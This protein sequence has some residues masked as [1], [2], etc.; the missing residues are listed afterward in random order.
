MTPVTNMTSP[1]TP[2]TLST[3]PVS[4]TSKRLIT[5]KVSET[6]PQ[7][8]RQTPNPFNQKPVS[9]SITPNS[10]QQTNQIKGTVS[11]SSL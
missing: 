10:P 2:A 11:T 8:S 9:N 6:E 7:H 4:S 3:D 1:T 5:N